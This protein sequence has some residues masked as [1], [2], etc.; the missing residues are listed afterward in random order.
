MENNGP[1]ASHPKQQQLPSVVSSPPRRHA[2]ERRRTRLRG[3]FLLS[4]LVLGVPAITALSPRGHD[5]KAIHLLNTI[6]NWTP[7]NV[8]ELAAGHTCL[9]KTS[10]PRLLAS[11][12]PV[13]GP[14][15]FSRSIN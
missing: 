3:I 13:T 14:S 5:D 10:A 12:D 2:P 4:L 6:V 9:M 7:M 15:D 8:S 1:T 11:V